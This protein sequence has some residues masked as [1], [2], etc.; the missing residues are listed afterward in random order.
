MTLNDFQKK[1]LDVNSSI[2]NLEPILKECMNACTH[3]LRVEIHGL[4]EEV[5]ALR[6]SNLELVK[7][8]TNTKQPNA[9]PSIPQISEN[10]SELLSKVND[11]SLEL[12]SSTVNGEQKEPMDIPNLKW[13]LLVN[14]M[15]RGKY[16]TRNIDAKSSQKT[17]L[18]AT[19]T[20]R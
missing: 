11:P 10:E 6:E 8:L 9:A 16:R 3:E 14:Q 18:N 12:K 13:L 4:K 15:N 17:K 7:M 20:L 1:V 2:K 19:I 5:R